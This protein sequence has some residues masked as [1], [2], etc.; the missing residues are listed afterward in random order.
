MSCPAECLSTVQRETL[1]NLINDHKSAKVSSAKNISFNVNNIIDVQ[2]CQTLF[3]QVC[4]YSEFTEI[5]THQSFPPY[6]MHV[7]IQA[8]KLKTVSSTIVS[9]QI[10]LFFGKC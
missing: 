5:W 4:S 10:F 6:S 2:I 1:A 3:F 9:S 8:Y 7:S